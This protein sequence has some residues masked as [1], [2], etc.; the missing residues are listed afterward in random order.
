MLQG[1]DTRPAK[2]IRIIFYR[3]RIGYSGNHFTRDNIILFKLIKA[4]LGHAEMADQH[5]RLD[6]TQSFT[7]RSP[8]PRWHQSGA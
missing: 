1:K 2:S 6:A 4:M 5:E 7:H 3:R 8:R